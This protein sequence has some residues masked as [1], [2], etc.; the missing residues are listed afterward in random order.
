MAI[1]ELA[2]SSSGALVISTCSARFCGG[3]IC[4]TVALKQSRLPAPALIANFTSSLFIET[5]PPYLFPLG[6][7]M[8]EHGGHAR[9]P[10]MSRLYGIGCG[11]GNGGTPQ[12]S[13]AH[14]N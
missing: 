2:D 1:H 14:G 6:E 10:C 3:R 7:S 5:A 13:V 12:I 11:A 8:D 9:P 4:A